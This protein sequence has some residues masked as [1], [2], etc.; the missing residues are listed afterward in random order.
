MTGRTPAD[1]AFA[2]IAPSGM[3][4]VN[5]KIVALDVRCRCEEVLLRLLRTP[6]GLLSV[7]RHHNPPTNKQIEAKGG[8]WPGGDSSEARVHRQGNRIEIE[9]ELATQVGWWE[10]PVW[11]SPDDSAPGVQRV[12][13]RCRCGRTLICE[14]LRPR[15]EAQLRFGRSRRLDAPQD[16]LLDRV[17]YREWT[18]TAHQRIGRG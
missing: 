10:D 2:M 16:C 13:V 5:K 8:R 3:F 14:R 11:Y 15:V 4:A 18:L 6:D 1:A 7:W 9:D 12:D 17:A